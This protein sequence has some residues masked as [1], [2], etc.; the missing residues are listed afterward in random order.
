MTASRQV[1]EHPGRG[2][3]A[4]ISPKIGE[5]IGGSI[6]RGWAYQDIQVLPHKTG[7][8]IYKSEKK[9]RQRISDVYLSMSL[10]HVLEADSIPTA[11][12]NGLDFADILQTAIVDWSE[13]QGFVKELTDI[14]TMFKVVKDSRVTSG[15]TGAWKI[16]IET[17]MILCYEDPG[18]DGFSGIL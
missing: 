17:F 14:Q 9:G 4:F 8:S 2:L 6:I 11:K 12:I 15:Q 18:P 10:G 3:V 7:W 1:I 5:Q 13:C 16:I